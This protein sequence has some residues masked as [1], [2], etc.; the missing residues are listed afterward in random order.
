MEEAG[1]LICST[2]KVYLVPS[3]G[4]EVL[5]LLTFSIKSER[6][7]KLMKSFVNNLYDS[8]Y[9]REQAKNNDEESGDDEEI[10]IKRGERK[11]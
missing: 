4:L 10:D 8:V 1:S 9:T 3:G 5:L 11:K 2:Y 7:F 6:I